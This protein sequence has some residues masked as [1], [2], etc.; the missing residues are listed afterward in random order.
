MSFKIEMSASELSEYAATVMGFNSLTYISDITYDINEDFTELYIKV[1]GGSYDA[2]YDDYPYTE[3]ENIF[4]S[5]PELVTQDNISELR[6]FLIT[7]TETTVSE[8]LQMNFSRKENTSDV[9]VDNFLREL[10][11][12]KSPNYNRVTADFTSGALHLFDETSC[13]NKT[14]LFKNLTDEE[15][16]QYVRQFISQ[17]SSHIDNLN[18]MVAAIDFVSEI[19][20]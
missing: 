13:V 10:E 8:I 6:Y 12:K 7:A 15:N 16:H 3:Y 1:E 2:P 14:V 19:K 17:C 4:W 20:I 11:A 18:L 9:Y 5:I